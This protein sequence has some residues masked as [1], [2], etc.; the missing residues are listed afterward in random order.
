MHLYRQARML[1]LVIALVAGGGMAVWLG[2]RDYRAARSETAPTPLAVDAFERYGGQ[3]WLKIDRGVFLTDLAVI[4]DVPRGQG[5][6]E[7]QAVFQV[8]LVPPGWRPNDPVHVIC[9][10]GPGPRSKVADWLRE[11][12]RGTL[13]SFTGVVVNEPAAPL[14]PTLNLV[15]PTVMLQEGG[16]LP[17]PGSSLGIVALGVGMLLGGL[18]LGVWLVRD[19]RTRRRQPGESRPRTEGG[20]HF[21]MR[22]QCHHCRHTFSVCVH[23]DKSLD[24][25]ARYVFHCPRNGS[26][27]VVSASAFRPVDRCPQGAVE[28]T[29]W[30]PGTKGDLPGADPA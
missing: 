28:G 6:R 14:F 2:A 4:R 1:L 3:R 21:S 29:V 23:A 15:E 16:R 24:P 17:D 8:P 12:G 27:F 18:G 30:Q 19:A 10:L 22:M 20:L 9:K 25:Q 7:D 11:N 13:R 26:R 5:D